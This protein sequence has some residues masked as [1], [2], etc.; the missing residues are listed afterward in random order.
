MRVEDA[1]GVRTVTFDR[2]DVK[3][4]FTADVAR[5]LSAAL[6][7]LSPE[8]VD[9]VVLTG[10]GDAFSAGGDIQAMAERDETAREAYERVRGTLGRVAEAILTAPVPVIAR[11]NGDA[12]GAG[13][14]VV[15]AC[16]FAYAVQGARF[17]A[18]FVNVGLV[19][20]AGG[21]VTLPRL[22]GLRAAKELAFTGKLISA[23][24]AADLDLVNEVVDADEL[25]TVVDEMA[26]TLASRPTETLALAKEAIHANL[27]RPWPDGLEREA[28][29]QTLAYDTDAHEEGVSAFLE[30]RRPDFE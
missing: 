19:P 1:D 22:V 15:A 4:A 8:A 13:T 5:D 24:R 16:D 6:E 7:N 9:A 29:A 14:S 23:E 25:D 20:D 2:P 10:D 30:K 17:G 3:N 27:G 18:S 12:V 21:T 11:V 26:E 28:Q